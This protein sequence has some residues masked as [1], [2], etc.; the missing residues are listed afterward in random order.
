VHICLTQIWPRY[1]EQIGL[2]A[3]LHD[4]RDTEM[5]TVRHDTLT[6]KILR[7]THVIEVPS[8]CLIHAV[9]A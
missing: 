2:D 5:D 3:M 9:I 6:Q 7:S 8:R 4:H 1:P